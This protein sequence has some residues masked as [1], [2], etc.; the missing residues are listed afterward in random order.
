MKYANKINAKNI[1]VIGRDELYTGMIKI[2]NMDTSEVTIL[3]LN[4]DKEIQKYFL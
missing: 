3:N 1:V 4:N 2:K